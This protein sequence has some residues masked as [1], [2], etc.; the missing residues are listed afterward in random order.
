[1]HART[2]RPSRRSRARKSDPGAYL[3][4]LTV[5]GPIVR[6][7]LGDERD[8]A[9]AALCESH[10]I[11]HS[12]F[13][14]AA[15]LSHEDNEWTLS[16]WNPHL[17]T[18]QMLLKSRFHLNLH[19][20]LVAH[21]RGNDTAAWAIRTGVPTGVSLL[22]M[23]EGID[24]GAIWA[25]KEL[26]VDTVI[27]GGALLARMKSELVSLFVDEWPSIYSGNVQPTPQAVVA[28]SL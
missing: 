11:H 8:T 27:K 4:S 17:L 14:K 16:L 19:P 26:A 10:N 7:V 5:R 15:F 18:Q 22:E 24:T 13:D 23:D 21:C 6:V 20:A 3:A 28:T 25:Q 9:I 1:M 12:V 2:Q